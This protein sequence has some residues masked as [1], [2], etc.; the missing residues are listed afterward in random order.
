MTEEM[1]GELACEIGRCRVLADANQLA[2]DEKYMV[3]WRRETE[4]G[5][6]T[7]TCGTA[8][9]AEAAST[10]DLQPTTCNLRPATA[11]D[12]DPVNFRRLVRLKAAVRRSRFGHATT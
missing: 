11:C 9:A 5:S 12:R 10:Y 7:V 4:S 1:P 8:A 3:I 6:C 2:D